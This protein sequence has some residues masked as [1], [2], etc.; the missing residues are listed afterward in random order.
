MKSQA[1]EC[2][3][4]AAASQFNPTLGVVLVGVPPSRLAVHTIAALNTSCSDGQRG[5][6]APETTSEST[7]YYLICHNL[8]PHL[9]AV[10]ARH[11]GLLGGD[12]GLPWHN[13]GNSPDTLAI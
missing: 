5:L 3:D 12:E 2:R 8:N 13:L 11:E 1:R 4:T 6:A 9:V 7:E 10:I